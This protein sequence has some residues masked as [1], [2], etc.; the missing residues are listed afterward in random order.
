MVY[1]FLNCAFNKHQN[2]A[3]DECI[4]CFEAKPNAK[5]LPCHKTHII[6]TSC[7]RACSRKFDCCPMCQSAVNYS[8]CLRVRDMRAMNLWAML[9]DRN[10]EV[11]ELN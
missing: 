1:D 6:C 2:T 5:A 7:M 8:K 11:I 4:I 3:M 10:K 9:M